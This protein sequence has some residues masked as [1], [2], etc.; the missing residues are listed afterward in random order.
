[1]KSQRLS[2]NAL[3]SRSVS[4]KRRSTSRYVQ[5]TSIC[6]SS[7][8][9]QVESLE[10]IARGYNNKVYLLKL[11][12]HTPIAPRALQPGCLP[13]PSQT[14][15]SLIFRT[16]RKR[17]Q[18]PP[19]RKVLNAVA[20]MQLVRES[21]DLPLAPMYGY[22]INGEEPWMLEGML[23]GVP[24]DEAW[25]T[26]DTDTRVRMLEALADVFAVRRG[27]YILSDQI[28]TDLR[29]CIRNSKP[30]PHPTASLEALG[31]MRRA[32]SSLVPHVWRTMKARSQLR[33]TTTRLG[34]AG[35]GRTPRRTLARTDGRSTDS[36]SVLRNS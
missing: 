36:T 32:R 25:Q 8:L 30:Y 35:S 13:F 16:V 3:P 23:P 33:K 31:M 27:R 7:H 26:A 18:T 21:T 22:D 1:M 24:M 2:R 19:A 10:P 14:P 9:R 6:P 29:R 20:T 12:P 4:S 17:S 5:P 34:S 11:L 15:T 28:R